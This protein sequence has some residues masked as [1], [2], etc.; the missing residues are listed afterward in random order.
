[1]RKACAHAFYKE[2]LT[3]MLEVLKNKIMDAVSKWDEEI[4]KSPNSTTMIDI[5][6]EFERIFSRNIITIAFGEDISDEKFTIM[7]ET[8]SG[9]KKFQPKVVSIREAIHVT[10]E[11]LVANYADKLSHPIN[12]FWKKTGHIYSHNHVHRT[13]DD[14][15]RKIRAWV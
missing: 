8:K 7:V 9:S 4:K 15:C 2:R 3:M 12:L 10:D 6:Y 14:N 1:M 13:I 5:A 11:L